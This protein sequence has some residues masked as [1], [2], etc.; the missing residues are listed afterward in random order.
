M[1]PLLLH[2]EPS[3]CYQVIKTVGSLSLEGSA[4][5]SNAGIGHHSLTGDPLQQRQEATFRSAGQPDTGRAQLHLCWTVPLF[6][7]PAVGH[8]FQSQ[9]PRCPSRSC[10]PPSYT[11]RARRTPEPSRGPERDSCDRVFSSV[12]ELRPR[13]PPSACE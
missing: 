11:G 2:G 8:R 9:L 7:T 4:C 10:N 12:R 5:Q 6:L 13:L 3:V 1:V